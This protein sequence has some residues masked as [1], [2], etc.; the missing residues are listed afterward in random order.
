M[1]LDPGTEAA[2]TNNKSSW[3]HAEVGAGKERKQGQMHETDYRRDQ[4]LQIG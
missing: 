1:V 2:M 4:T 3:V